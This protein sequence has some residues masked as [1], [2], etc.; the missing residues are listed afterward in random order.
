MITS[1]CFIVSNPSMQKLVLDETAELVK[2]CVME[3]M[4]LFHYF[5]KVNLYLPPKKQ[6]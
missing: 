3:V 2:F 6:W 1:K 5:A 4:G